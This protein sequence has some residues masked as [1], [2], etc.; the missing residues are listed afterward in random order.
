M[1]TLLKANSVSGVYRNAKNKPL[2]IWIIK[3]KPNID[4]KFQNKLILIGV[5]KLINESFKID[6]RGWLFFLLKIKF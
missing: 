3:H 2:I 1:F 6:I 5:G 4:P